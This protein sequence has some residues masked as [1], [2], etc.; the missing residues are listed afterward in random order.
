MRELFVL[1]L[2][3]SL[4]ACSLEPDSHRAGTVAEDIDIDSV[5]LLPYG[6]LYIRQD[7]ATGVRFFKVHKGY[8][9][10][11]VLAL[12]VD[13]VV[14]GFPPAYQ[15]FSRI[16]LP[17]GSDCAFD[18][19]GRDTTVTRVFRDAS[20]VRLANSR[21]KICDSARV[22]RGAFVYDSIRGIPGTS[23]TFS[24]GKL[25]FRDSSSLAARFLF[26]DTI[27]PCLRFNQAQ[28]EKEKG[29]TLKVTFS[30]MRLEPAAPGDSC[31]GVSH[32]DSV[33]VSRKR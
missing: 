31:G 24:A 20:T 11:Q 17:G 23:T 12:G 1:T 19:S 32:V 6:S 22:A 9:C 21:G 26:T 25:T 16:R 4:A 3:A 10:S 30:W 8:D 18:S 13:S 33:P 2:I 29:D 15:P 7:S 14:S 27:G 5:R 28:F